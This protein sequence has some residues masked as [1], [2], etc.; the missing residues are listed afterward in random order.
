MSINN[1]FGCG[2]TE[3]NIKMYGHTCCESSP[4]NPPTPCCEAHY[5]TYQASYCLRPKSSVHATETTT[6]YLSFSNFCEDNFPINTDEVFLYHAAS[7]HLKIV[8]RENNTFGVRLVDPTKKGALIDKDTCVLISIVPNQVFANPGI[9]RC[10]SGKF[11]VPVANGE[12]TLFIYNGSGIPLGSTVTFTY[13]GETGSYLVMQYV[14]AISNVYT[15]KVKNVGAGH[16]PNMII[17]GGADGTCTVPIEIIT[18]IDI[19]NLTTTQTADSI[20][21]CVNGSPRSLKPTSPNEVVASDS[22]N[23][24]ILQKVTNL[25]CCVTTVG[26]LKFNQNPVLCQETDIA[27]VVGPIPACFITAFNTAQAGSTALPVTINGSKFTVVSINTGTNQITL[28]PTD[29][30]YLSGGGTSVQYAEGTKICLGECCNRCTTNGITVTNAQDYTNVDLEKRAGYNIAIPTIP[31]Q[32]SGPGHFLIG[33]PVGA[34]MTAPALQVLTSIFN[35]APS[36]SGPRIPRIGDHLLLRQKICNTDPNGCD[37]EIHFMYNVEMVFEGLPDKAKVHYEFG[38]F[39]APS[40]TLAD[41]VTPN[42]YAF[43]SSSNT[44]AGSVFGPSQTDTDIITNTSIGFGGVTEVKS[45]PFIAK[46]FLD[47]VRLRKCDCTLSVLWL[48]LRTQLLPG[49]GLGADTTFGINLNFRRII[50][51]VPMKLEDNISN[52]TNSEGFKQ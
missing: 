29:I 15:Y 5:T 52:D 16:T 41:G 40:A 26:C 22:N 4:Q 20:T 9:G 30:G 42:P 12:S 35:D 1:R 13:E 14:S 10:V 44:E 19:C 45:F 17:D 7:G 27:T 48:Y 47:K 24:F 25:D 8:S 39:A 50:S 46:T 21:A 38:H 3:N 11:A 28:A 51:R 43:S 37:Q 49:H 2:C 32:I 23:K 6:F 33:F 36:P 18:E 31:L 34:T